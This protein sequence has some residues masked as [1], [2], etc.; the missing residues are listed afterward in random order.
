MWDGWR[1]RT[2]EAYI[3]VF[4]QRLRWLVWFLIVSM[5]SAL[6]LR[7]RPVWGFSPGMPGEYPVTVLPR[8]VSS[9]TQ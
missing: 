1:S 3:D 5:F 8:R 2:Q 4:G 7:K 6:L 9:V